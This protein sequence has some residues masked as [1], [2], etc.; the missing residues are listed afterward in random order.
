MKQKLNSEL[1][2]IMDERF[3][4]DSLI[5]LAT[6]EDGKPFV[7]TVNGC[8][9]DGSFYIVTYALSGKMRQIEKCKEV[10]VCGDW[11]TATGIGEN[12]G[13]VLAE[14]NTRIIGNL[15][16]AFASWYSCGHVDET[17]PNTCI[18]RI[19]LTEGVLF[20]DGTRYEIDFT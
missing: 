2:R 16:E 1:G 18:L 8:Y 11:F 6:V 4:R 10:A 5:A 9:M 7:R 17:D 20:S 14:S 3:G 13:H 19:R 15:R 12:M